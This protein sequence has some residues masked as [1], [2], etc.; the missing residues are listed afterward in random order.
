MIPRGTSALFDELLSPCN[1]VPRP[2]IRSPTDLLLPGNGWAMSIEYYKAGE[3]E[4]KRELMCS[5]A[6]TNNEFLRRVVR[7]VRPSG[8]PWLLES[9][10]DAI[11]FRADRVF[12]LSPSAHLQVSRAFDSLMILQVCWGWTVDYTV[13]RFEGV[14]WAPRRARD[15]QSPLLGSLAPRVVID[16][17]DGFKQLG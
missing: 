12:P 1:S 15:R 3:L 7:P 13:R 17:C 6:D 9:P 16:F 8:K 4:G 10:G 5:F 14:E 2:G 11:L